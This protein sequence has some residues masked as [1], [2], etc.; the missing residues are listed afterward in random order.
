M[1]RNNQGMPG[2]AGAYAIMTTDNRDSIYSLYYIPPFTLKLVSNWFTFK[3]VWPNHII[4]WFTEIGI[5]NALGGVYMGNYKHWTRDPRARAR[6]IDNLLVT[7]DLDPLNSS[8]NLNNP[9]R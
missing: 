8:R 3:P 4:M 5:P 2:P 9:P 7:F 1:I 6:T